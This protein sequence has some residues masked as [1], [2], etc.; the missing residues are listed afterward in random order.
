MAVFGWH[1]PRC[2]CVVREVAHGVLTCFNDSRVLRFF[3][4]GELVCPTPIWYGEEELK[5]ANVHPHEAYRVY[6]VGFRMTN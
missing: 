2:V 3:N 5:L 4:F 6:F 1:Y